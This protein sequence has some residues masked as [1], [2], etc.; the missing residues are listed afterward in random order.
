MVHW[1][2]TPFPVQRPIST[3]RSLFEIRSGRGDA[4][5]ENVALY[6]VTVTR[7][8]QAFGFCIET[9]RLLVA[10]QKQSSG[11]VDRSACASYTFGTSSI[12]LYA[13]GTSTDFFTLK[14]A[15]VCEQGG[16]A[17]L[18]KDK[19]NWWRLSIVSIGPLVSGRYTHVLRHLYIYIHTGPKTCTGVYNYTHRAEGIH[20]CT[21]KAMHTQTS[22]YKS[23]HLYLPVHTCTS[24]YTKMQ[25][26]FLNTHTCSQTEPFAHTLLCARLHTTHTFIYTNTAVEECASHTQLKFQMRWPALHIF[27]TCESHSLSQ[28]LTP[29]RVPVLP[30]DIHTDFILHTQP[31]EDA[32][33]T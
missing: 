20:T 32:Q 2:R 4:P 33:I 23:K 16:R 10:G 29:T 6:K 30:Q 27:N 17:D 28:A 12:C 19:I 3:Y 8:V 5:V 25:C 22:T 13:A 21:L 15:C 18:N 14:H 7:I 24:A 26:T 9:Q 11:T 1:R 31:W